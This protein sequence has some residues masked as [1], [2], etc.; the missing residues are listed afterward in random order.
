MHAN[1]RPET[2]NSWQ[3]PCVRATSRAGDTSTARL[4]A[5]RAR[6]RTDKRT[7][8][9]A[10]I[11]TL[12]PSAARVVHGKALATPQSPDGDA[13]PTSAR[14][15]ARSLVR[16]RSS[17]ISAGDVQRRVGE[18]GV[19]ASGFATVPARR[20]G[21]ATLA[22]QRVDGG[23]SEFPSE[24]TMLKRN[25][26]GSLTQRRRRPFTTAM[27]TRHRRSP[28]SARAKRRSCTPRLHD[29]VPRL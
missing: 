12:A 14:H 29:R 15:T 8:S 22:I 9:R 24:R 10:P 19:L 16:R 28:E 23:V 20:A 11:G 17:R 2:A 18:C 5:R 7:P 25:G 21:D 6:F 27:K 13:P 4:R 3:P 26:P 1:D